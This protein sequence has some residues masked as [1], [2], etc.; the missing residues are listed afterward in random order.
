MQNLPQKFSLLA[1]GSVLIGFVANYHLPR[2]NMWIKLG[3]QGN[4]DDHLRNSLGETSVTL[5]F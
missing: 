1:R 3:V 2:L 4:G 5:S